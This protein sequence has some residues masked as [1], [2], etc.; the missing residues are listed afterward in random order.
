MF[1]LQL[2][3]FLLR[4]F[5]FAFFQPRFPSFLPLLSDAKRFFPNFFRFLCGAA[6]ETEWILARNHALPLT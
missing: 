2:D 4:K 3:V 5:L 6:L 1:H